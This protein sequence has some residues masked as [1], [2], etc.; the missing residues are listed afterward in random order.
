[1][2]SPTILCVH[3]H[4][5]DEA[6]FTA[7]ASSYYADEGHRLVL[8]TCTYGQL[9][10]DGAGRA[11]NIEGH[12]DLDTRANR[13]GELQRAGALCGFERQVS[14]G[15]RDSGMA[16]WASHA[17]PDAFVNVDVER[18]A[19]QL[20]AIIDAEEA[21]V[22]ITYDENGFYGHPDH[23]SAH[24]VTRRAVELSASAERLFYPVIPRRV[25]AEFV[26]R[27]R[28]AHLS[29]PAWVTDA[30]LDTEDDDVA[31]ALDVRHRA[32]LKQRAIALHATQIDNADLVTMSADLFELLFGVEYYRLGWSRAAASPLSNLVEGLS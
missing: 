10:I 15:Y 32:S 24:R 16:G 13:A 8:V 19:R 28:A 9:G 11:G 25:L 2:K 12:D 5:D 26:E 21:A 31:V 1:M 29:M 4:P 30:T 20:A 18:A 27:A 3:A 14:L 7:G 17:H 22:V 23:V 6:L